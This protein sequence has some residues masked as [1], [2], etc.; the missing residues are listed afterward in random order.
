MRFAKRAGVLVSF[1]LGTAVATHSQRCE[2]FNTQRV[3]HRLVWEAQIEIG[4]SISES[5]QQALKERGIRIA[6]GKLFNIKTRTQFECIVTSDGVAMHAQL[7]VQTAPPKPPS[8]LSEYALI[9]YTRVFAPNYEA[10]AAG[11]INAYRRDPTVPVPNRVID[12]NEV[13]L[14]KPSSTL[15]LTANPTGF[16]N[17]TWEPSLLTLFILSQSNLDCLPGARKKVVKRDAGR[18]QVVVYQNEAGEVHT[19]YDLRSGIPK[20]VVFHSEGRTGEYLCT[21][22]TKYLGVEVPRTIHY[23][24]VEGNLQTVI[25]FTLK[26]VEKL[27]SPK[28]LLEVPLGSAVSDYRYLGEISDRDLIR[29]SRNAVLYNWTGKL[30][31]DAEVQMY[32]Y[33]MGLLQPSEDSSSRY[34]PLLFAPAIIFFALAAYFYFRNRRR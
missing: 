19:E 28:E 8:L 20:R 32:A 7:P 27:S 26:H 4:E 29:N 17:A 21:N 5:E 16:L 3:G 25:T 30:L 12:I 24:E 34:S 31:S 2:T 6:G 33:K 10:I 13:L 15:S 1:F 11:S 18:Q 9:Q 23:R 22:P 14:Y